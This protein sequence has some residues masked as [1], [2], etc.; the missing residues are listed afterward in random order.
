M[1]P[2]SL[3]EISDVTKNFSSPTD[4]VHVLNGVSFTLQSGETLAVT[5]PSGSGKSTLLG[6]MAGLER[7]TAGK[8]LYR[9]SPLGEMDEEGLAGWRRRYVGFIFQNFRLVE[10][11][12]ALE[13]VTLPLE[14]L[15]WNL[16]E[17]VIRSKEL[18]REIGMEDRGNHF[19]R[20]LSGGEQ[21][22]I[23]IAR[24]Y[25]HNP[26]I[27]F[28]DE[29]TGSLD[30]ETAE[31]VLENLLRFQA[32]KNAALVLVTH[33]LTVASRMGRALSLERGHIVH[34]RR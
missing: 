19:P 29:P 21:Q 30:R 25:V 13:N 26:E 17:A 4:T 14:I 12:T 2:A 10:S 22:R 15:G 5:G 6:L 20:Q 32:G 23:A 33:D 3:I 8:I 11:L 34:E 27:V 16:T 31:K 9:G 7:P 18:L 24:A 28:A 1:N